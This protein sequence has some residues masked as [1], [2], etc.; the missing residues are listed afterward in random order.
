[1]K[2]GRT[3]VR[4]GNGRG[5]GLFLISLAIAA[6]FLGFGAGAS[7]SGDSAGLSGDISSYSGQASEAHSSGGSYLQTYRARTYHCETKNIHTGVCSCPAGYSAQLVALAEGP[8][9]DYEP[10]WITYGYV[11]E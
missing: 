10:C 9:C 5:S 3:G 1:M 7:L 8:S 11:C 2:K 4:G 6:S